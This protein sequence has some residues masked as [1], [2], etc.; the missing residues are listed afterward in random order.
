MDT[1][2]CGVVIATYGERSFWNYMAKRAMRSL[3]DQHRQP[4]EVV[5]IHRGDIAEAR[6]QGAA[7]CQTDWIIFLDADDVLEPQYIS[8]MMAGA[9]DM[10]Y[11][12][13]RYVQEFYQGPLPRPVMLNQ[14]PLF[15][16]NYMVI[17]TAIRKELFTQSGG[18]VNWPA[19]E[20]WAFFIACRLNCAPE[21]KPQLIADAVYRVYQRGNSRNI[22]EH[23]KAVRTFHAIVD[24]YRPV[25]EARNMD[26]NMLV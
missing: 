6:N 23:D 8:G 20:D 12:M 9:G 11:P 15:Q 14:K 19:Y 16:G 3:L 26:L 4:D 25:A 1:E 24:H 17:G 21:T 18:F 13:V 2:T 5:R 10:R 22:L 7:A